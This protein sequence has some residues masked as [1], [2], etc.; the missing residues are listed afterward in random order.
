VSTN[1]PTSSDGTWFV[2]LWIIVAATTSAIDN[3]REPLP[4]RKKKLKYIRFKYNP[5]GMI[6][7]GFWPHGNL[8]ILNLLSADKSSP[9][10]DLNPCYDPTVV[11]GPKRRVYVIF[12]KSRP[13]LIYEFG[14]NPVNFFPQSHSRPLLV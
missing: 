5:E 9:G 1:R 6:S 14:Y 11:N 2:Q 10:F 3:A 7:Y 4:K 8:A 12:N 13:I